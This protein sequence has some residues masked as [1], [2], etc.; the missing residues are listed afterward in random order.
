M[1][2]SKAGEKASIDFARL[3]RRMSSDYVLTVWNWVR[4]RQSHGQKF[5]RE[6][7]ITPYTVDFLC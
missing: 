6:H 2:K 5:R 3:Q 1:K 4:N 7:P